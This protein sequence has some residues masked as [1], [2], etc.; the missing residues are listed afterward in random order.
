M[1]LG[2]GYD[3]KTPNKYRKS[4][5]TGLQRIFALD[6]ASLDLPVLALATSA[7]TEAYAM[8]NDL[9][10]RPH[11]ERF[12]GSLRT[13]WPDE[14]PRW[15][16]RGGAFA[17]PEEVVLIVRALHSSLAGGLEVG[18]DLKTLRAL[19]LGQGEAAELARA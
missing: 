19:D 15:L 4:V 13:R 12:L 5:A 3:H 7:L 2:A 14:L 6:P 11:A 1:V 10:L 8:T 18:D 9:T 16:G 17:G